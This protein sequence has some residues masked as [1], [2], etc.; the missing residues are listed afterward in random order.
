VAE[1]A[2]GH[3]KKAKQFADDGEGSSSMYGILQ[4]EA[5]LDF[6]TDLVKERDA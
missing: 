1:L 6:E 5:R 3:V 2:L 4:Q